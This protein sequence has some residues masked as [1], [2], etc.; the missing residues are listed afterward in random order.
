[1]EEARTRS[2]RGSMEP[3]NRFVLVVDCDARNLVLMSMILQ[4]LGYNAC[5]AL[6]VGNALEIA[7]ASAPSLIVTELHLKGLSGL[8][9][10]Q[11]VRQLDRT[12]AVP[13]IVMTHDLTPEVEQQCRRAGALS[14]IS[15][16]VQANELYEALQPVLEPGSRRRDVR[17]PTRLSVLVNDRPLDCVDGEC[18]TN[19]SANG[20]YLRTLQPYPEGSEVVLRVSLQEE[21]VRA[22]AR[23]VY[24]QPSDGE[25]SGMWGIG[26]QFVGTSPGAKEIIRRFIN[27][28][29]A[30]GILPAMDD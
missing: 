27:D 15:K 20:M 24:C 23:V 9:L 12:A 13:V 6:G 21:T 3:V 17:I 26:V 5:S 29:V 2:T 30:F 1:M 14:C 18:A 16:P 25:A 8:D 4:R 10:L 7:S 28:E 22:E 11:H 19:L